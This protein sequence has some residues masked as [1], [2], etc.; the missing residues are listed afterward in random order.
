MKNS[1]ISRQ[2]FIK[3][4]Q[5]ASRSCR[6]SGEG[7]YNKTELK[8]LSGYTAIVTGAGIKTGVSTV[9]TLVRAGAIVIAVTDF[10]YNALKKYSDEDDFDVWQDR[11]YL[12]E[13]DFRKVKEIGRFIEYIKDEF[14]SIDI[15]VNN[16]FQTI[17]RS[18]E[19]YIELGK[20][21]K[22]YEIEASER[23]LHYN[24]KA[25]ASRHSYLEQNIYDDLNLLDMSLYSISMQMNEFMEM[26]I[27]NNTAPYF[28]ISE[29]KECL[30]KSIH[31][32][33][34]IINVMPADIVSSE[35][36][37]V[38]A[39]MTETSL[40]MITKTFENDFAEENIFIY[41]IYPGMV[42][43]ELSE[44]FTDIS[45]KNSDSSLTCDDA[46]SEIC[47]PIFK[48]LD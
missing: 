39:N 17:R 15:I 35:N 21:E 10:P 36:K 20:A 19:Y 11:L 33:K 8:D 42:T 47:N 18:T 43:D 29:L 44:E 46:G 40:N 9:L 12:Y 31:K 45:N 2:P 5:T 1:F 41:N 23:N 3:H 38:Y 34:F 25:S 14:K 26:Q 7:N 32:N 6:K 16:A 48:H 13:L 37:N 24:I 22:L 27:I 4:H 28:I 30:L